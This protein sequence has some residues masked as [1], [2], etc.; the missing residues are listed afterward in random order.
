MYHLSLSSEWIA[1]ASA[2]P[3]W[4]HREAI[5]YLRERIGPKGQSLLREAFG[6]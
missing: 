5:S 6:I 2:N 4:S 1:G 3:E